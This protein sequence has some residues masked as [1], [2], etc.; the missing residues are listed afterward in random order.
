MTAIPKLKEWLGDG[1]R[2]DGFE[3]WV[4]ASLAAAQSKDTGTAATNR[5]LHTLCIA[6]VEAGRREDTLGM[7]RVDTMMRMGRG[8]GYALM[9]AMVGK[10]RDDM[11]IG[12]AQQVALALVKEGMDF[13]ALHNKR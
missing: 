1:A 13:F 9:S 12:E 11:P 6:M 7:D 4:A 10:G 5:V 8:L 3:E 2:A